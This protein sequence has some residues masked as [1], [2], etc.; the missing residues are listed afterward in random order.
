MPDGYG[1]HADYMAWVKEDA[2]ARLLIIETALR[3]AFSV[4]IEKRE[5]EVIVFSNMSAFDLANAIV[6]QPLIK[7][8]FGCLQYC[9]PR[10]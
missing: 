9:C 1:S 2:D 10:Y 6:S 3:K 5:V 8:S 4:F 7:A